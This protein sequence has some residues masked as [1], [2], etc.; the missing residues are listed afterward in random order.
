MDRYVIVKGGWNNEKGG[1]QK[2]RMERKRFSKQRSPIT[3]TNIVSSKGGR[4]I[5]KGLVRR[6]RSQMINR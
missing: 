2:N 5:E 3:D 4:A 6:E 1:K